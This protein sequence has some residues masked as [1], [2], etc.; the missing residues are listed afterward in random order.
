MPR[1]PAPEVYI[2]EGLNEFL[3]NLAENHKFQKWIRD[4]KTV[5]ME[6]K[7]SGELIKKCQIPDYYIEKYGVNNLYRYDHPEG[8]YS[9]LQLKSFNQLIVANLKLIK[10]VGDT[11]FCASRSEGYLGLEVKHEAEKPFLELFKT[12]NR[13][14][15]VGNKPLLE[16]F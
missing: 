3:K 11:P 8:A 7:Y 5:L 15:R 9:Q 14:L 1:S 16:S 10:K 13:I 2:V 6:H 4:M 12:Y